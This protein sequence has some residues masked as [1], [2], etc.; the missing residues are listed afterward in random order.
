MP[1]LR[2]EGPT[3]SRLAPYFNLRSGTHTPDSFVVESSRLV[4]RLL[5]SN[6]QTRSLLVTESKLE[7]FRSLVPTGLP[8]YV[9]TKAELKEIVGF[10]LHRGCL[11]HAAAPSHDL[12]SVLTQGL[13]PLTIV[14][15]GLADPANVGAIIR[16]AAAFGVGLV[17]ADTKGASPF[18][19]KA[20]RTSAGHLFN[21]PLV[22]ANPTQALEE[23]RARFAE[24][25]IIVT[26]GQQDA[27]ALEDLR[28]GGQKIIVFGNEGTGVSQALR[29]LADSKR[30]VELSEGVDSLNVAAASALVLYIVRNTVRKK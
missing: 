15:E 11:A 2:I 26:T 4:E 17:I 13:G 12:E 24:A 1:I 21:I 8:V 6:F 14:L 18:T 5:K 29:K 25:E 9:G 20:A 30:R 3:D 23:I 27:D 16:N 7:Q 10:D 19:R 28:P 22:L